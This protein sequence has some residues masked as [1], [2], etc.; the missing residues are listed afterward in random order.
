MI[1][2]KR[3]FPVLVVFLL[4]TGHAPAATGYD[5]I[6]ALIKD[7]KLD[8]ALQLTEGRLATSPDDIKLRFL[9]GLILTRLERL[10]EAETAFVELTEIN[11]DLPEPYNNLAVVY[12]AQ[13]KYSEAE[14]ALK[15]A[16]NTHPSYAT[17]HENLGDIYAKMASRAYNQALELDNTN[18]SARAKLSLVNEMISEPG[19]AAPE[20]KPDSKK[21]VA[22]AKPP[23]E[24]KPAPIK[25]EIITIP[26]EKQP[27]PKKVEKEKVIPPLPVKQ[28]TVEEV[29]PVQDRDNVERAVNDWADA[30]SDQDVDRYLGSYAK[31]FVPDDNQSLSAWK[32]ERRIRLKSPEYIK[33]TLSDIKVDLHG[34]DYAEVRF[35]QRYQSDTYGDE[36]TKQL[37]MRKYDDTWLITQERTR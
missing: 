8:Q 1:L 16:I 34:K 22:A 21:Q 19:S 18:H 33:V 35:Q 27:E 24:T 17:A 3:L 29:K 14:Q 5:D 20:K 10:P 28:A 9:K 25:P 23:A 15:N 13:G 36:V 11:P 2:I 32:E 31:E 30:W 37:L 7:N 6:Q 4:L 26:P 12:A